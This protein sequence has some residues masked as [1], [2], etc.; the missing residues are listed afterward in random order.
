MHPIIKTAALPV[1]LAASLSACANGTPPKHS[2]PVAEAAPGCGAD[3]FAAYV[4]K[5]ASDTAIAAIQAAR[6]DK[7][8]RVIRPG[9]AVTMDY[10]AERL[11]VDVDD[12]GTIR[13]FYCS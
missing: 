2:P 4:G 6:G 11:N 3:Q 1:L 9:M 7:P 10:R 5:P 13:R 12:S 8:I